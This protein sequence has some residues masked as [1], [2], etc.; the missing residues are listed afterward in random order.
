[1]KMIAWLA[2]ATVTAAPTFSFVFA[3]EMKTSELIVGKWTPEGSVKGSTV[4]FTKEGTVKLTADADGTVVTVSGTYKFVKDDTVEM[5]LE[6]PKSNEKKMEKLTITI[7]S[8]SSSEMTILNP[9]NEL[10]KLKAVK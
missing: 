10:E 6:F 2:V 5:N 3:A 9:K 7:K 4:E 1:M 8:I